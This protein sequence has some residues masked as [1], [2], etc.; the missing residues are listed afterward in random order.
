MSVLGGS[1]LVPG[2][3]LT[4]MNVVAEEVRRLIEQTMGCASIH[5]GL[6]DAAV[7]FVSKGREAAT[8]GWHFGSIVPD[9]G[10]WMNDAAMWEDADM[11]MPAYH[12][13][14]LAACLLRDLERQSLLAI[15]GD[16]ESS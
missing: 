5:W 12:I 2:T 6:V 4:E 14:L 11:S 1:S 3:D 13:T 8:P 7:E 15:C 16:T 9:Q 10:L